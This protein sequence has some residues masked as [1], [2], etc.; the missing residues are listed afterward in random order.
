MPKRSPSTDYGRACA[1]DGTINNSRS[2][3]SGSGQQLGSGNRF[4]RWL[5]FHS[6]NNETTFQP[7]NTQSKKQQN[8]KF[9]DSEKRRMSTY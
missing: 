7:V 1:M 5:G 2:S 8:Q 6:N 4:L 3:R 9:S